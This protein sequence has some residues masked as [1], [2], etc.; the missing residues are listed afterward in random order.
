MAIDL[1]RRIGTRDFIILEKAD[2]FGGTWR[3]NCY[4]GCCPDG[5]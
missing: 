3:Q 4:P 5:K 1:I 2:T